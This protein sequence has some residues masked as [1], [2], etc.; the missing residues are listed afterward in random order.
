M[1]GNG[2]AALL[3]AKL[4]RTTPARVK[5]AASSSEMPFDAAGLRAFLIGRITLA[6][7]VGVSPSDRHQMATRGYA[8]L[9][10]GKLAEAEEAFRG[11]LALDPRDA[12]VLTALAAIAQRRGDLEP[13]DR[14]YSLALE[15][16]PRSP[17]AAAN[18]G[19]VRMQLERLEEAA[20]DL[21]TALAFDPFA[22]HPATQRARANLRAVEGKIG[23]RT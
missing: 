10:A 7:L 14:L 3:A 22:R 8:L 20:A 18:R 13:A 11:L 9:S 21:E 6:D 12:Y 19:E 1:V 16:D 2:H 5:Q 4:S 23:T 17:V 15:I